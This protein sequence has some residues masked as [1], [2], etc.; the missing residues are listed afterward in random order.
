M[1]IRQVLKSSASMIPDLFYKVTDGANETRRMESGRGEKERRRRRRSGR[2]KDEPR[3][4]EESRNHPPRGRRKVRKITKAVRA[5][6]IKST[7]GS[8][9]GIWKEKN[10]GG[11]GYKKKETVKL[12]AAGGGGTIKYLCIVG[13]I[14]AQADQAGLELLC[15]QSARVVLG[16]G[17]PVPGEASGGPQAMQQH[18]QRCQ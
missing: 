11:G 1:E 6:G 10:T 2:E 16:C 15:A 14:E 12:L 4:E 8:K 7:S 13:D 17:G 18:I 3:G 5:G 9:G